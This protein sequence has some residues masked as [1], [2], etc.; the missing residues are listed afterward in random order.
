[1]QLSGLI[2]QEGFSSI[3]DPAAFVQLHVDSCLLNH[4][5][6]KQCCVRPVLRCVLAVRATTK[7][8][9]SASTKEA[10]GG[11]KEAATQMLAAH[12]SLWRTGFKFTALDHSTRSV[13]LILPPP[14]SVFMASITALCTG[15]CEGAESKMYL[16][17]VLKIPCVYA[18][19][20]SYCPLLQLPQ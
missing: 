2:R 18:D 14:S 13:I 15:D 6:A 12:C 20:H 5:I 7:D 10:N 8:F 1:V 3:T 9:A 4:N 19:L 11:S 17:Y 16:I